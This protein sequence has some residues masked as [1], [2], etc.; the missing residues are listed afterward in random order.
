[1]ATVAADAQSGAV[2]MLAW[3]NKEA[4]DKTLET[5]FAH[6]WSRSRQRL[7]KKGETSGHLQRVLEIRV[8]CDQ[9]ALLLL[10]EPTGGACH[11][12]RDS[13]FYRVLS[14]DGQSLRFAE[15]FVRPETAP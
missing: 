2:L 9:D 6:Y 15:A 5:G 12:G 11:T 14:A 7:W 1:M 10:V 13:C 4:L 8:D 3:M